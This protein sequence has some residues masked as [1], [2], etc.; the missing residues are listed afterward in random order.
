[1]G[2]APGST[3]PAKALAAM[4][5]RMVFWFTPENDVVLGFAA[6]TANL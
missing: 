2:I 4:T 5:C 6:L 1:M 3:H